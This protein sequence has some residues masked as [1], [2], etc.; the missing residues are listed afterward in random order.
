VIQNNYWLKK[1]VFQ[2]LVHDMLKIV[3]AILLFFP[4]FAA[5]QVGGEN[6]FNFLNIPASA[7]QSALGGKTITLNSDLNQP[8]WNPATTNAAM[9]GKIGVSYLNYL[10]DLKLL[11]INHVFEAPKKLGLMYGGIHY[12][13][14]GSILAADENG[15]ETGEQIRSYDIAFTLGNSVQLSNMP[16]YA[17][18]NLKF[19]NAVIG[20]YSSLGMG[21]DIGLLFKD[22]KLPYTVTLA[23]R[24]IGFQLTTFDQNH[25]SLPLVVS[26][27]ASYL[28]KNAP[29]KFHA[30]IDDLQQW[31]L[32][33]PNP[34]NSQINL[35]GTVEEENIDFLENLMRHVTI[36]VE[37]LPKK[38]FNLMLGYNFRRAQELSLQDARTFAG[39]NYGF[40][41]KTK[42]I[43]FNYGFS[44]YHLA[45]SSHTFSLTL[46]LFPHE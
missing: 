38:K 3:L 39:L 5:A 24:N 11:S 26:L 12:F 22:D 29:F 27:G 13:T 40:G 33:Y 21:I 23:A 31:Q 35:D 45:S 20:Q 18:V 2:L 30:T 16:I 17:G 46:D 34:A 43:E 4:F 15:V 41:F 10:A 44:R 6:I 25:E 9:K 19:I 37:I 32:A 1:Y 7:R 28:L 14:Y 42:K 8:Y 36:G